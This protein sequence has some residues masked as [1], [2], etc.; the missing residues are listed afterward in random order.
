MLIIKK[1]AKNGTLTFD[2]SNN[3][4]DEFY[5]IGTSARFFYDIAN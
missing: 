4:T 2:L 5:L 1:D 3:F